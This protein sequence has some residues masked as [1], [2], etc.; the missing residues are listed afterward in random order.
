MILTKAFK[1]SSLTVVFRCV[2][3]DDFFHGQSKSQ[4]EN[5]QSLNAPWMPPAPTHPTQTWP[6]VWRH[7]SIAS[8]Q[9]LVWRASSLFEV[10]LW[11][12]SWGPVTQVPLPPWALDLRKYVCSRFSGTTSYYGSQLCLE[13]CAFNL[14]R[15]SRLFTRHI[16]KSTWAKSQWDF[17]FLSSKPRL[18]NINMQL[19]LQMCDNMPQTCRAVFPRNATNAFCHDILGLRTAARQPG[20][21]SG[22]EARA[23]VRLWPAVFSKLKPWYF[24]LGK[25]VLENGGIRQGK[26]QFSSLIMSPLMSFHNQLINTLTIK[27]NLSF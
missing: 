5:L 4:G 15:A 20:T 24:I 16:F 1:L 19:F 18:S 11:A 25:S 2:L 22:A 10:L 26:E 8:T 27:L 23:R 13:A 7:H 17:F 21:C 12:F 6:P 14:S 3:S 9:S